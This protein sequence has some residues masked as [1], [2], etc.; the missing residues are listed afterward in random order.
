MTNRNVAVI[1]PGSDA[2]DSELD[3]A[4][5]TG[6]LLASEGFTVVTG[7][8]GGIMAAAAEG[9]DLGGGEAVGFLPGSD[10]SGAS[11][12]L[13]LALPTGLGELRNWL[14]VSCSDAVIAIGGSW[15]TTS[16]LALAIR[17]GKPVIS[18]GGWKFAL[19]SGE[20]IEIP[21]ADSPEQ[22]IEWVLAQ[23]ERP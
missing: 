22:A 10:L 18:L 13:S 3:A 20:R 15:G 11:L 23:L 7:G 8:L 2:S 12:G 9:A 21:T 4:R 19:G 14:V 16:E 17:L 6:L 5:T 1:G